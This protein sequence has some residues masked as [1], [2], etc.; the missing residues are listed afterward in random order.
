MRAGRAAGEPRQGLAVAMVVWMGSVGACG[1]IDD[2]GARREG[3]GRGESASEAPTETLSIPDRE[4]RGSGCGRAA[5]TDP[6]DL[7]SGR[8]VARCAPGA[9]APQPL[10]EPASLTIGLRATT[11]DLAPILLADHYD[12]FAQ[13]NLRVELTEHASAAELFGALEDGEVDVV[14]GELDAP[15]FD[16]AF[17]GS[18]AQVALGGALPSAGDDTARPQTG[19]WLRTDQLTQDE[20]W[21]D[22]EG[23][24]FAAPDGIGDAVAY[25]IHL[26]TTQDDLSLNE[27]RT[28]AIGGQEA[29]R[30]LAGGELT[31][32]WL[33]DPYWQEMEDSEFDVELVATLPVAE[34]I[35]G[36]VLTERLL[37][38][39]RDREVGLAFT[40]AVIRTINSYLDEDYQ[41]DPEVVTALVEVT[42]VSEEE[43]VETPPWVF[44][45]EIRSRTTDRIQEALVLLGGVIYEEEMP[46][47]RLVDRSLYSDVV[48]AD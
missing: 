42:G 30:R 40:R 36:V 34:S 5:A 11:E 27:V 10:A 41:D 39:T 37:D 20:S 4:G 7:A 31:A 29:A 9:P 15:F 28:E 22:L 26:V 16:S 18:G 8:T 38:D 25:P 32:A 48:S 35:S 19:L 23:H 3:G 21:L 1:V 6:A 43:I 14:V 13:E 47:D 12:E 33:T 2:E 44:D 17:E 45:W 46:E 24:T